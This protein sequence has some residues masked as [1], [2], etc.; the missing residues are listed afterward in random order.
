[1]VLL[2]RFYAVQLWLLISLLLGFK[3]RAVIEWVFDI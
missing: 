3:V 1:M 2:I